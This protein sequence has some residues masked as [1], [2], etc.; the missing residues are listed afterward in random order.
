MFKSRG[1][2]HWKL[3]GTFSAGPGGGREV[4]AVQGSLQQVRF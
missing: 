1:R 3:E 2:R 4:E